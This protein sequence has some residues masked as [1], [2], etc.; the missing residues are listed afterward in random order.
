MPHLRGVSVHV[1]DSHGKNLQEWGI[2]YLRQHNEGRRVS[3]Y[4]QSTPDISFQVSLQP[5]IPFTEHLPP[6]AIL[7]GDNVSTRKKSG[8]LTA[9]PG[10]LST[11]QDHETKSNVTLTSPVRSSTTPK[12]HSTPDFAFLASLYLDGRRLPERKIIVYIDPAD[13]DFNSPDGKV[14]FKHRWVQAAN[15]KM[16]EYAWVFKEQAIETV[17]DKLVIA[18]CE[19]KVEDQDDA[20]LIK[21]MESSGIDGQEKKEKESKVGQIVVELRRIMLGEKRVEPNFR[22]SHQEGQEEDIDMAGAPRAITHATG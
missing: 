13:K 9:G 16:I 22:S 17:F 3:A 15:G 6:P 18:G 20:A 5:N 19:S 8:R 4:I 1:T 10:N 21:A 7:G 12:D 14:A 2:R 11:K